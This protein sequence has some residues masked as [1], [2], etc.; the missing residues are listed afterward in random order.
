[1]HSM[2]KSVARFKAMEKRSRAAATAAAAKL[3]KRNTTATAMS[4]VE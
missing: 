1:M 2:R 4:L 3:A